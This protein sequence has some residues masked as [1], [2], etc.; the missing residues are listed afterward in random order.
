[1]Q[2]IVR[3]QKVKTQLIAKTLAYINKDRYTPKFLKKHITIT[4][5]YNPQKNDKENYGIMMY[6]KNRLIKAYERVGCQRK[7]NYK[8]VGVIGVIDCSFLKP[9]HN[10]QD[11]DDTDEYRK[12]IYN[13]G[14]KLEEYWME[15]KH[16][17]QKEDPRCTAPIEDTPKRPDQNWAQCD[18][19]LKWRKLPDGIDPDLL[20]DRWFC[21]MNPDP[22]FRSCQIEEEPEDSE[23]EQPYQKIYKQQQKKKQQQVHGRR[24]SEKKGQQDGG[25]SMSAPTT[26][27]HGSSAQGTLRGTVTPHSSSLFIYNHAGGSRSADL[28][29][30]KCSMSTVP[31]VKRKLELIR[32]SQKRA[33]DNAAESAEAAEMSESCLS[34][35]AGTSESDD[36]IVE[37]NSLSRPG[38]ITDAVEIDAIE[39]NASATVASPQPFQQMS[40]STQTYSSPKVKEEKV[41]E[42][43]MEQS[44]EESRA[45]STQ[46]GEP[47]QKEAGLDTDMGGGTQIDGMPASDAVMEREQK[48]LQEAQ[49]QQ[50]QLVELMQTIAHERDQLKCQL[51]QLMEAI[52]KKEQCD[53]ATE[54]EQQKDE[55]MKDC[56]EVEL[57]Q[58][59]ET[60]DKL[61][62]KCEQ[63]K[64]E[65]EEL[66]REK[67]ASSPS[68]V[69][70]KISGSNRPACQ[71]DTY[72][73]RNLRHSV[74]RLL[75]TYVPALDLDQVNYDCN[76]IDEIL[77]QV[78]DENDNRNH[79]DEPQ[80]HTRVL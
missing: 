10:K 59:S 38:A 24:A 43:K 19:C 62:E 26:P 4:F 32:K 34:L 3:G 53:Q 72:R 40:I 37:A 56:R 31:R 80:N 52:V 77:D 9:T 2:I 8:G 66:R 41:E 33:K 7:T 20:P 58:K 70:G 65:L 29:S 42:R 21:H 51:Q 61:Q 49:Q 39:T 69:W 1:M 22:Q 48:G 74:G 67:R 15:I 76:V 47:W 35:A 6:H 5:G 17:R 11:F 12:V 30:D 71:D 16:K 27:I 64:R 68:A 75:Q 46:Q 25:L 13:L 73:L 45:T 36:I 57:A 78:L 23:D 50:D 55:A 44:M 60:I 54:T 79:T 14:V 28:I 63:L 18:D